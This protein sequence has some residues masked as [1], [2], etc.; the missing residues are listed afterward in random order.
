MCKGSTAPSKDSTKKHEESAEKITLEI[1][2]VIVLTVAV[3]SFLCVATSTW[4]FRKFKEPVLHEIK[5]T[6]VPPTD[7]LQRATFDDG[8]MEKFITQINEKESALEDKYQSIVK[9]QDEERDLKSLFGLFF[10]VIVSVAGFFGYRSLREMNE[11]VK[12]MAIEEAQ[13]AA[14]TKATTVASEE[15][16]SI[17]YRVAPSAAKEKAEEVAKI[18]ATDTTEHYLNKNLKGLVNDYCDELFKSDVMT[19][20][21]NTIV[22]EVAKAKKSRRSTTKDSVP[23][24]E[25]FK[26]SESSDVPTEF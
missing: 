13:V 25:D 8:D 23:T 15:A 17:A 14:K 6:M 18:T 22:E 2:A 21:K 9:R 3:I 16:L 26:K 19:D 20:F 7:S 5:I 1:C 24:P 4:M 12:K 11:T 10:G